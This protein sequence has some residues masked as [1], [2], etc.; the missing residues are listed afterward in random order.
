MYELIRQLKDKPEG[1]EDA[2]KIDTHQ[3]KNESIQ[4]AQ[5]ED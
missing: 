1:Y 5:D 3:T 2:M 4:E